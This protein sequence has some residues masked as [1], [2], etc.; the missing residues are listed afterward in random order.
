MK[1]KKEET[2]V[3]QKLIWY[4]EWIIRSDYYK[5][6]YVH[7]CV[8]KNSLEREYD[9]R[10]ADYWQT[11]DYYYI[12]KLIRDKGID[13]DG[14]MENTKTKPVQL[15]AFILS[16]SKRIMNKNVLAIDC[17][18]NALVYNTETDSLYIEKKYWKTPEEK[19]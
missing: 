11:T 9:T 13:D 16:N 4:C 6:Y 14:I 5:R 15:R 17:F 18:K 19:S 3:K 8:T 7:K 2:V 10:V 12:A 1:H